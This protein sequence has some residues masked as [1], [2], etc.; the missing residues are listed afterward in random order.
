M[1]GKSEEHNAPCDYPARGARSPKDFADDGLIDLAQ[2][3]GLLDILNSGMGVDVVLMLL[4]VIPQAKG[5]HQVVQVARSPGPVKI[6]CR[7]AHASRAAHHCCAG[8]A[9]ACSMNPCGL[10]HAVAKVSGETVLM[11]RRVCCCQRYPITLL[12]LFCWV[13]TGRYSPAGKLILLLLYKHV[14][15]GTE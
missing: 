12:P 11:L 8:D 13:P 4:A 14:P 6:L 2:G 7:S 9:A 10:T 5:Q 1:H 3:C 15:M